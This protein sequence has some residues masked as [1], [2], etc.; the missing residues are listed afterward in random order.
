MHKRCSHCGN[1]KKAS[2]GASMSLS[3][4]DLMQLS[5]E[6][7]EYLDSYYGI[8]T[9]EEQL[10]AVNDIYK[11]IRTQH[12][13]LSAFLETHENN[14]IK[15]VSRTIESMLEQTGKDFKNFVS[16]NMQQITDSDVSNYMQNSNRY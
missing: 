7:A 14:L 1:S 3:R 9:S 12:D 4:E 10:E 2:G 16:G 13:I 6:L 15:S 8:D 5:E 11:G